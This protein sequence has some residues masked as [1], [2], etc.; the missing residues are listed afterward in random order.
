MILAEFRRPDSDKN[1]H[2]KDQAQEVSARNKD[3]GYQIRDL[4]CYAQ[5]KIVYL[6]SMS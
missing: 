4:E 5:K 3:C 6:L 2:S 1:V